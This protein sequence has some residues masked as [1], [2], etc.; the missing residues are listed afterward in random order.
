MAAVPEILTG[1]LYDLDLFQEI[2]AGGTEA[3]VEAGQTTTL[4]L[5]LTLGENRLAN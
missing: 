5:T 1:D 3:Q 2:A 4:D